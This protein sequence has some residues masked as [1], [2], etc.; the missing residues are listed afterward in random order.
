MI[1]VPPVPVPD[2]ATNDTLA[3]P[4]PGVATTVIGALGTVTGITA[5]EGED[6]APTPTAFVAVT[7]N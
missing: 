1:G 4:F 2:G 6:D 5:I 7:V 3:C